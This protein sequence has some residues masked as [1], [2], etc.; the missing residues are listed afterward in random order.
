M[1]Y[2]GIEFNT[3]LKNYP[4]KNGYFGKYGGAYV[5]PELQAAMNEINGFKPSPY[6]LYESAATINNTWGYSAWDHNW[7]SPELIAHNRQK[8]SQ[9]GINYLLNVGPD[10]L[11]RIPLKSQQILREAAEIFNK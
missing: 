2:N 4:D 6:G 11:G 7:K 1:M 8:L 3:Y 10:G 5:S 9:L